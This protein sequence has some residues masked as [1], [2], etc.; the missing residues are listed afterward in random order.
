MGKPEGQIE[1]YLGKLC[2][3][4]DILYY[5]FNS[6]SS[7]GVPDRLLITKGHVIF[8]ELKR[9]INYKSQGPRASQ[10]AVFNEM[11]KHGATVLVVDTKEKSDKLINKLIKRYH[12]TKKQKTKINTDNFYFPIMKT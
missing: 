9:P 3:E 10:I 5:K 4:Y 12:L 1:D 7:L 8:V 11:R 6:D 2:K